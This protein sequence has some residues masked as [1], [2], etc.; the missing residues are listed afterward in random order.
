VKELANTYPLLE[1]L[2]LNSNEWA[3]LLKPYTLQ[4]PLRRL[5]SRPLTS[6]KS[7]R[8]LMNAHQL[9]LVHYEIL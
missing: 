7:S 1:K 5:F 3:R 6:F 2:I 8:L 9:I 4:K